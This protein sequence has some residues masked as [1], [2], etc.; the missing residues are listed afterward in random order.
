MAPG[1]C[2][3]SVFREKCRSKAP[4]TRT[5]PFRVFS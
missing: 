2:P 1:L 4:E 5:S 3:S